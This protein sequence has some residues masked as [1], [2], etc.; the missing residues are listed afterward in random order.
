MVT[1]LGVGVRENWEAMLSGKSGI[2]SLQGDKEFEGLK[3][4]I[5]GKLPKHFNLEEH[6][7]SVCFSHFL[8]FCLKF[9]QARIFS[10]ANAVT[11]EAVADAKIDFKSM[12]PQQRD[13]VGIVLANQFGVME[14]Y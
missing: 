7:T 6:Q 9:P 5:G 11:K 14:N 1:P 2:V 4:Q 13:R 12:T 10:L 8:T 3:S